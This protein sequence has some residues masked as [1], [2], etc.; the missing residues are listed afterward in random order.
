MLDAPAAILLAIFGFVLAAS[1]VYLITPLAAWLARRTGVVVQP[2]EKRHM[3]RTTMPLLGGLA[4][5]VGLLV[6]TLAL[7]KM[8]PA[9]KAILIGGSIITFVG[10]L[11]DL[12]DI[13]PLAK[14]AGQLLAIAV[15]LYLNVRIAR[16]TLPLTDE[17]INLTAA[18]SFP[19]T[20]LWMATIINMVNFI[21]GLDGLAAGVCSIAS[22][23]FAV[24]ALSL[25]RGTMGITAAILAGTTFAFLRFNFY[26]ASIFMGDAGSMLLGYVL[27][28]VSVQ[29]VLKGAATVALIFPLLVLGVP[30]LDL[31]RIVVLRWRAGVPFYKADS[32]HVHHALVLGAGFSQ[33]RA[34]LLLY[35][36]CVLLSGL[37]LAMRWGSLAWSSVLGVAALLMTFSMLRLL[38]RARAGRL[39]SNRTTAV[40]GG[41]GGERAPGKGEPSSRRTATL[42]PAPTRAKRLGHH[43]G[44]DR[45][46]R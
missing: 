41:G 9:T 22:L 21:D 13:T 20:V 39:T 40:S 25:D 28:V 44:D 37:A 33:R 34:V 24:I 16:F 18:V 7:V 4:M 32:D 14:F 5:Y 11:D 35:G 17:S 36:W 19:L 15:M 26:P 27:G 6:P 31:A 12:F 30:F 45:T 43:R 3:H 23:T 46:R 42:A 2:R 8:E 38:A 1:I 10:L 29:G